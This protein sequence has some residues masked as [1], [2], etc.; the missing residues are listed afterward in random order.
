M[1]KAPTSPAPEAAQPAN[2]MANPAAGV[3]ALSALGFGIASQAVGHWMGIMAAAAD[4]SQRFWAPL[5]GAGQGGVGAVAPSPVA[6][7]AATSAAPAEPRGNVVM[8]RKPDRGNIADATPGETAAAAE[9]GAVS[10]ADDLKAISGIGPKM[11]QVLNS[12]GVRTYAQIAAWD[13]HAVARIEDAVGFKGRI[14]RDGW[15]A[16]ASALLKTGVREA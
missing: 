15:I 14:E 2:L 9:I 8:L 5:T 11:Q 3:M 1:K 6:E 10:T 7:I 16:Q 12:L 13:E 4:A